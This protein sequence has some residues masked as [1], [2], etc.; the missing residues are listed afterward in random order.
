[1]PSTIQDIWELLVA[2]A[3]QETIGPL[4]GIGRYVGFGVG[5]ALLV[6]IGTVLLALAGLRALQTETGSTFTGNLSWIPYLIVLL[7]LSLV[8]GAAV[9]AIN[10]K[11]RS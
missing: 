11:G 4:K 6:A 7:G 5:G 1:M 8:I 2:Y 10:R 9:S 3:R